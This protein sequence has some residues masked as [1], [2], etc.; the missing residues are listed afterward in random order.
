[1]NKSDRLQIRIAPDLKARG[2]ELFGS[3]GLTMSKAV[4]LFIAQALLEEGLP[5]NIAAENSVKS[6]DINKQ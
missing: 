4:N 6:R 5:F 3:M 2:E 1:M